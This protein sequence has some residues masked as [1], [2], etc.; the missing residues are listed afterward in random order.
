MERVHTQVESGVSVADIVLQV[1]PDAVLARYAHIYI[2]GVYVAREEWD[3]AHPAPGSVV[4]L[5][6]VPMGGGGGGKNPLR[7]I[8]SLAII[9]ASPIIAGG[10][11]GLLG[12]GAQASFLGISAGR[13][14]TSGVSLL[15]RLALNAIAPPSRSR[16]G[17]GAKE[18]PTLFI[19]GAR[20]QISPFG[21]VPKVL[22]KHRFVPPQG[23]WPYT[24][25]IG[26]DQYIRMLFV[27]GYGPLE[28]SDLKIGETPLADFTDVETETR[29]GYEDDA[30]LTLYS[31]SVIQNDLQITLTNAGGYVTRTTE[32]DADEIS[33]DITLPQGLFK[34]GSGGT[35]TT[36]T[37]ALDIQYSP[38]G[39]NQWSAGATSYKA[40]AQQPAGSFETPAYYSFRDIDYTVIRID[41]LVM[42]PAS[43]T[44]SIIRGTPF[45]SGLD[46]GSAL[47]PAVPAG[48]IL[49]A[50]IERRSGDAGVIPSGR[51]TDERSSSLFG[52]TLETSA[53]FLVTSSAQAGKVT[54]AAGGLKYSGIVMTAKQAA[55]V[56]KSVSFKVP[57]GQY[58]VR[59]KRLTADA[60]DDN[61]F[62]ETVW[63]ALRTIRA[64]YP[65][66]MAG[67]AVTALRIKATDQ[68]SGVIDRFN[69]VV[70]SILPDWTGTTWT[71]QVT[72][73]PAAIFRHIL[74]GSANA[75]PLIDSRLDLERIQQWHENCAAEDR[76]FNAVIDYDVSVHE[77]LQSVAAAGRASPALVDGK[78]AVVEDKQQT[79]PVQHFTPRNTFG[80]RGEK[81]FDEAPHALRVRFINRDKGW[82]QDERLV[83]DDGYDAQNATRYETLELNGITEA[84][85]AWRDGRYHI[86]TARLRPET[87]S[88]HAD[89]EHIVCTRGDLIRFTHDVP[90]F[91]LMSARVKSVS[92]VSGN[93]VSATL[94]AAV[95]MEAGKSYAVRFRRPDGSSLVKNLTTA[96]GDS[97]VISF[98][99]PYPEAEGPISGD[100]ALF[101][102]SGQESV[103]LIV[104][105]I[106]PQNDLNARITCVDAAPAVH[107]AD[108]G[109]IPA[110]SSQI[111]VPPEMQK[112][113]IPVLAQIQSGEEALI[114]H[115]D[116]S[117]TSR[118]LI[119]LEPPL[120]FLRLNVKASIRNADE[121]DFYAAEVMMQSGN[122]I[123][124]TDIVEGDTYDIRL[125]YVTEAGVFSDPL[126]I[127]GHRVEGT[128]ALP[129]DVAALNLNILGSTAHLSWEAVADID[130]SHYVLRYAPQTEDAVWSGAVDIIT[131]IAGTAT[132]ISVPFASGTY[133]LKAVDVGGRQ[134]QNAASAVS[135][136]RGGGY[137]DITAVTED[138]GFSGTKMNVSLADGALRLTGA[139]SVDDWSDVDVIANMD[140][141]NEGLF[142]S[143]VYDFDGAIDLG[144]VYVSRLSA[145]L[146]VAG[147]DIGT[148]VDTWS[149]TDTLESWDQDVDP[150]LFAVE[151]QLRTTNDDPSGAPVWGGWMPFVVGD[152]K[153]RACQFRAL[154]TSASPN[155]TPAVS[156]LGVSLSMAERTTGGGNIVSDSGGTNIVFAA[157]FRDTP[158]ISVTP[159]N[160]ATGDYFTLTGPVETGF[161][162]RFFNSGGTGISRTFDYQA[163][164]FGEK[165]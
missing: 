66:N 19:Q 90:L 40:I 111:T 49:L 85:Q 55:A 107:T 160:M 158:A 150:S 7:T 2:D 163:T 77:A 23:A 98:S 143:G 88:F 22:G 106:E 63:T 86:A 54:V 41:R 13:L 142:S 119:T 30:P 93:I 56:R 32:Q 100:L 80:F 95:T 130:L 51:I 117:L 62:D 34:F 37:V 89:I 156:E 165:L 155:V 70:H 145:S 78:W 21:R 71:W 52:T 112:P 72:S 44:V 109:T 84:N 61:T 10:I 113:P 161:T 164:G 15:G 121:T 136:V 91:G 82:L 138:P 64:S 104:K 97:N 27:W 153:A 79:V 69:G 29:Q 115:T 92:V 36:A 38:A 152:Y 81:S 129:S 67:L 154:L 26:N 46:N 14:I 59:V 134:S 9:A 96:A 65:V 12:A 146:G 75:R 133:L 24:E 149:N 118:I 120:S 141:G 108:T 53:D 39:Q 42:D 157:A 132:S 144:G 83:Y 3:A 103:E 60:T 58:D 94:D 139:D 68:L 31:N 5:R 45:R 48:K 33:L 35:K 127:A 116:G 25:T 126:L 6:M 137:A 4:T 125:R 8:L 11:A 128:S 28:I 147:I 102:E 131:R 16:F 74:Q 57:K 135:P 162:I 110:F 124:V 73:N 122:R 17:A 105:A 18:S 1:Q 140:V 50:K 151:L 47:A 43:G 76:E 114:R 148:G 101:G 87:Y 20:N 123:S 159:R 99:T